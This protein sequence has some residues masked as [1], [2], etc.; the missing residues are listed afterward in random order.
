MVRVV[1]I[2]GGAA[3]A[4]AAARAR[5]LDPNAEV[6]LIERGSMITHAPCGMPYAI[7]G[8]VKSH[9]ELQ[10]YTPEEFEKE[11]NIKVLIRTEVV[12]IDTDKKT[13][14]VRRGGAQETIIWDKL[15]IATGAK[16][17]VPR[18]AGVELKGI[19][20]MR[21]PDD[22]PTIKGHLEKAKTVAVV[23]GGYIGVEMAEVLL[24]LGKKVLLF[25]QFDQVLPGALDADVAALVAEEMRAK[26]VELHL[27]EK[28]VEF[29]GAEHVNKVVTEKGEYQVDEVVL[30]VGVRPDVDLAVRAGAK[31]GETGAVYVNEYMETTVP[32]VY[33]AG[34]VAEK[35]HRVTGRRVWIPLAPTA[36]KEGQ[37]AGG[38]AVRG[39][40]LKFPGVVGTAVTKFYNLYIARTGLSEKEANAL[41]LK[42]QSALIK[43]RTKAHYMPGAETVHVKLIAEESTGRLLGGQIVGKSPVVAAYADILAV[44]VQSGYAVS[45]LFFSDI[46]YMPD[47][48]PVWHPLIVAAR[49]L[50]R[51]KL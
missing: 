28:V 21:H 6:I 43:A 45:D 11:R 41:G 7:G 31:L 18:I 36:N 38:N 16:P 33:A 34:D 9:E 35:V 50:S 20:T 25:E 10:T 4:S 17:L 49:V 3:G 5:R 26:G 29:R 48:A 13:V 51:G 23:G 8:I 47:T 27:G 39:R 22:V 12:D 44:A 40:V 15:V 30:A 24:E 42:A 37:V 14:T 1:V 19:L 2:G 46:G 32:D